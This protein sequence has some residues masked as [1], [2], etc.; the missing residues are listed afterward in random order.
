MVV[1]GLENDARI[2]AIQYSIYDIQS[3]LTLCA[4]FAI[5]LYTSLLWEKHVSVPFVNAVKNRDITLYNYSIVCCW[6]KC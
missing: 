4:Y 5:T 3:N 1:Y 6:L 2:T